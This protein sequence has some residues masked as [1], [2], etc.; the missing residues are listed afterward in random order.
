MKQM[1]VFN[2]HKTNRLFCVSVSSIIHKKISTLFYILLI[3]RIVFSQNYQNCF[4]ADLNI[5][6]FSTLS[7][8]SYQSG[9]QIYALTSNVRDLV[10]SGASSKKQLYNR[11]ITQ[12]MFISNSRK[13]IQVSIHIIK[14]LLYFFSGNNSGKNDCLFKF[15]FYFSKRILFQ[16]FLFFQIAVKCFY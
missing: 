3:F 5:P 1:T 7:H 4:I 6:L 11:C 10:Y 8:N 2:N 12:T 14:E 9:I 13:I 15:N 16:H